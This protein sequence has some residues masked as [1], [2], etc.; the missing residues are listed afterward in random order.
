MV[1]NSSRRQQNLRVQPPEAEL[2]SEGLRGT[3]ALLEAVSV[4]GTIGLDADGLITDWSAGA[5]ELFG[6]ADAEVLGRATSM[7]FLPEDRAGGLAERELATAHQFGRFEFDGLR[8]RKNGQQFRAHV[9]VTA[10]RDEAGAAT[11]FVKVVQNSDIDEQ[12][13]AAAFY[14]F[15]ELAPDAIVVT[16][17]VGRIMLANAQTELMFGYEREYLLGKQIEILVPPRFRKNH[18]LHRTEFMAAPA[19]RSMGADLDLWGL[20]RDGTEFPVR[21]SLGPLVIEGQNWVAATIGDIT[22]L[23]AVR[24]TEARL[25]AVVQSSDEAIISM[26]TDGAIQTCNPGAARLLDRPAEWLIG[27]SLQRLMPAAAKETFAGSCRQVFDGNAVER[28]KLKFFKGD[29]SLVDVAA[30]VFVLR[31]S[32]DE[33]VGYSLIARDITAEVEMQRQLEHLA[34]FDTLTG[35][36]NRSE[37]IAR[38]KAEL[39]SI[40]RPGV[41][42][43][44]LYCD[45]DGFKTIN[46]AHGHAAGDI[47]LKT[48]AKRMRECVRGGDTL[49]RIGGDEFMI[50]LPGVHNRDEVAN[51][52]EKIRRRAADPIPCSGTTIDATLSIGVTLA[53][54]GE[55]LPSLTARVDAAM[56]E[57]KHD[58]RNTICCA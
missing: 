12:R 19:V 11:G 44:A 32:R 30:N 25:A 29:G 58:G 26:T 48:L 35:L 49:G 31:D 6:Y 46:D 38:F 36:A 2:D 52:A 17:A 42:L 57:A 37:S 41:H 15:L 56:Y 39:E 8:V 43:G 45:V 9:I 16:N 20:R 4:R 21:V 55:S 5:R 7:F 22:E 24:Q 27:Q 50:L 14:S 34:R 1:A 53:I 28:V 40:R 47:V 10:L 51:V 23:H 33:P 13:K 3:E 54:S 18:V